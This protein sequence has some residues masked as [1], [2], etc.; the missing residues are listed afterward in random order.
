MAFR[1]KQICKFKYYYIFITA[2][3]L[4]DNAHVS[5]QIECVFFFHFMILY[6]T[7]MCNHLKNVLTDI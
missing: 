3:R 4:F 5:T 1:Y 7:E 2:A 6:C